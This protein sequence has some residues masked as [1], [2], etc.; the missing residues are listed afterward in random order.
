[1]KRISK[2]G[3]CI[4]LL[5]ALFG[6]CTQTDVEEESLPLPAGTKVDVGFRLNVLSSH[7]PQTRSITFTPGGTFESDTLAMPDT[8]TTLPTPPT[9]ATGVGDSVR[10]KAAAGLTEEQE[11]KI[12][13]LWV[14]QYEATSGKRLYNEYFGTV[15][16]TKDI[17]LQLPL[18]ASGVKSHVYFIAN[19]GDLGAVTDEKTLKAK[20]LTCTTGAGVPVDNR[21]KMAGMWEGEVVSGGLK[22]IPVEMI[23]LMAKITFTYAIGGDG[24]TFTPTAVA[25]TNAPEVSRVEVTDA[26]LPGISYNKYSGEANASGA[27]M[28]WYLGENMAGTGTPSVDS[29]KKKIGAG[30]TNATCIELTGE[31]KQLGVE[32]K[33]VTFRFYP[34]A[35]MNNYDI[36]RN[37][38]YEMNVTLVGIDLLDERITVGTIPP[39]EVDPDKIPA[40]GG[41]KAVAITTRPGQ[42]WSFTMPDWLTALIGGKTAGGGS[43]VSDNKPYTIPFTAAVNPTAEVREAEIVIDLQEGTA[44]TIKIGQN[45]SQLTKGSDI[46]LAAAAD[47]EGSSSFTATK[48]LKWQASLSDWLSWT[49]ANPA[50]SGDAATGSAQ[51][52][53]IKATTSNPSSSQ[54]S[55]T[56]TVKAGASVD[57]AT[58]TGLKQEIAVSQAGS[59]VNGSI[60]NS[61]AA[62]GATGSSSFTATAGLPW[63]SSITSGDWITIN[64]GE[65]GTPTTGSAQTI[66]YTAAVN[67]SSSVRSGKITVRAGDPS[68]GP[69]GDIVLNQLGATLSV[70]GATTVAATASTT[71]YVSTFSAT[72]GLSWNVSDNM[73]WLTLTGTTEGTNNTTGTNQDIKYSVGLNP[74]ETS[75]N[76]NITVKAGNAVGGTDAGLTK[77]I[78]ITQSASSLAASGTSPLGAAKD[79]AGTLKFTGTKGL[80]VTVTPPS[81]I[82]LTATAP[83]TTTGAEQTVG[84]KATETNPN[85]TARTAANITV[86][87]GNITKTVA[88]AQS[89]SSL[90]ASVSSTTAL[91]ATTGAGGTYTMNGTSGLSYSFT[92]GFPSWLTV[93]NGSASTG[94]GTT[95]GSNQ[96]LTYKTASVNPNGAERKATVT[97][98][99]GNISKSVEIKQAASSF[100]RTNPSAQIA[101]A[102]NSTVTGSVT[103]TAGLAWTITPAT[104][105]GITVSPTSGTGNATITFRGAAN[106]GAE[107]TGSF[108]LSAS[109]A[110]PART[111][112]FS[113]TQ[114][115]GDGAYVGNLQVCKTDGGVKTWS[116]ANSY[117]SSLIAEEKSDWRLPSRDELVTMYKKK[118]SLQNTAGF[119]AFGSS[120]YWSSTDYS[121]G[122]HWVVDFSSGGSNYGYD[123]DGKFVRCVRDKN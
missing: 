16:D 33:D 46:S 108:T 10:T 59:T 119:T 122:L 3:L 13:N 7:S 50:A 57:D 123:T 39:I 44:Q 97:I 116:S 66:N 61:I 4:C 60:I 55:G 94:G 99:A 28:C 56:I 24:F 67:P 90:T 43:T 21:C 121:S 111:L 19:A 52:L 102:A 93:T 23:R 114:A 95:T 84:Y 104:H 54:R 89:A 100:S 110:S 63:T 29:N 76:G 101:A 86:K 38:H 81:W 82:A 20:T 45:A 103:A 11:N 14:G 22:D 80:A 18:N 26:Q 42:P 68:A 85:S 27:T 15:S 5:S 113:A 47:S 118:S 31:A 65:T 34:G 70:S 1:M 112:A 83:A 8:P 53:K 77:T 36:V 88:V 35:D 64:S 107:R 120:G 72:K 48:G 75:R 109:D 2:I 58:Y 17:L 32:Y 40:E 78:A 117:C 87:A 96:Q 9:P 92:A 71:D 105:N 69:T 98:K 62:K 91:A 25:L 73:D 74:N 41:E 79:A 49:T 12:A 30:V 106:T 6:G 51:N 115:A 37:G